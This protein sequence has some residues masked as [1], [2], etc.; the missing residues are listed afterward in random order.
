MQL[1][2]SCLI[3]LG[4]SHAGQR[5]DVKDCMHILTYSDIVHIELITWVL[6]DL[7]HSFANKR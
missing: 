4:W 1:Y 3:L 5:N 2:N 7:L 6:T